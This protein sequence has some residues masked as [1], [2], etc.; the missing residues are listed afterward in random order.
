MRTNYWKVL[1]GVVMVGQLGFT[2]ITPP[3]VMVLLAV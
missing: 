2:L 1:R 3:V